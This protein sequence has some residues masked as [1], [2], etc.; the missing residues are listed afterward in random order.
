MRDRNV[1]IAGDGIEIGRLQIHMDEK[2]TSNIKNQILEARF[3]DSTNS[4]GLGKQDTV[5]WKILRES[6]SK[7]TK[8]NL[9]GLTS[10]TSLCSH[11]GGQDRNGHPGLAIRGSLSRTPSQMSNLRGRASGRK[12]QFQNISEDLEEIEEEDSTKRK[13]FVKTIPKEGWQMLRESVKQKEFKDKL[14]LRK[15]NLRLHHMDECAFQRVSTG[16]RQSVSIEPKIQALHPSI[17]NIYRRPSDE[18]TAAVDAYGFSKTSVGAHRRKSTIQNNN[19]L[20]E[21]DATLLLEMSKMGEQ[22]KVCC[23]CWYSVKCRIK[24]LMGSQ[25]INSLN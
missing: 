19:S 8:H 20:H 10:D 9:P 16:R 15:S 21:R 18:E 2:R 6:L 12:S 1:S 25:S 22:N 7:K 17:Q 5:G 3:D 4:T 23:N 24:Q 14:N 13:K 11:K